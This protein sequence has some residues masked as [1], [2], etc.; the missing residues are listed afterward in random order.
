[1]KILSI[2]PGY[3]RL[4]I[5]ILDNSNNK[6]VNLIFSECFHTS[7]KEGHPQRLSYIQKRIEEVIEEYSPTA[8]AIEGLF[9]SVNKRTAMKVSEARGVIISSAKKAGLEVFEYNPQEIKVAVGGDGRCDKKAIIR[10]VPLLVKM[11]DRK[12]LDDEY[13]AIACG[14]THFAIQR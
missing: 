13:D 14:L 4:G 8:L 10:M 9:F 5:A 1:M 12:R 2:D 11:D 3:E 6:N 7:A